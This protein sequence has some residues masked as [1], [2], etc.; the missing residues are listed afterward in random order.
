MLEKFPKVNFIGHSMAWWANIDK[1]VYPYLDYP[2]TKV[3]PG[4]I[5]DKLLSDYPNV[6]GDLSAGSELN[7]MT[8]DEEHAREFLKKHQDKLMFG[9][10]CTDKT[11]T[12]N[13][14]KGQ[15]I[16]DAIKRFS[17]DKQAVRKILCNNAERVF[18]IKA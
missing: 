9:T 1:E 6:F 18:K 4:G 3:T 12:F 2:T 13:D 14:C 15:R 11:G 16:L 10:D 5:T 17:P 8:R 7:S